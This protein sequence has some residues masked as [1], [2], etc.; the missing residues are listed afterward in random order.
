MLLALALIAAT[1][2]GPDVKV[3]G[4]GKPNAQVPATLVVEPAAMLIV[5]CDTDADGRT[6]RAEL[7]RCLA[8]TFAAAPIGYLDYAAWQ[9]KWLGD[10]GALPS[11]LEVDRDGNNRVS[12][13]EVQAH[14]SKLF[15]RLD[16]D[17]DSGVTRAEALTIRAYPTGDP[18][19]GK[20]R[21]ERVPGGQPP[22]R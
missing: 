7:D 9:Q 14:F 15:S 2:T 1:Q 4:P 17:A 12:L 6:T 5:A 3:V 8:K 11:P 18:D 16:K 20:R 19:R 21:G 13:D 10:Q 22:P